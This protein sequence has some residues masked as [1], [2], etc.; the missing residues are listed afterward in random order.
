MRYTDI[1]VE[2]VATELAKKLPSLSKH[3][4]STIDKLMRGIAK[5]HKISA[6]ALHDLFVKKYHK[7]PDSWIKSKLDETVECDLEKE[8]DKFVNWTAKKLNLKKIPKIT[9][10]F[11]T[12]E[13]QNNHHTGGHE[14]GS[15]QVWVYAKNRN[16]V[17]ILR[18][19]FHELVHV[20]QD[21]LGMIEPGDSYPGSPIEVMADML[22][23]K[24]IKI[25]GADNHHIFQ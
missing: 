7:T 10:S 21:E 3:N 2:S 8:V 1:I 13:A 17:D 18:T 4:Y 25:Y 6:E 22:A 19:V 12:E 11:D 14:M 5:K 15:N 24:Y 16:L 9:L 20:R 23:G